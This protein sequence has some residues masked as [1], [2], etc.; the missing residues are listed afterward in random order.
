MTDFVIVSFL[1]YLFNNGVSQHQRLNE[2]FSRG[3]HF[4]FF[5]ERKENDKKKNFFFF[6]LYFFLGKKNPP[7]NSF[8]YFSIRKKT[9]IHTHRHSQ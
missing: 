2:K 3:L 8:E 7:L 4:D 6:F 1:L 9:H 5:R